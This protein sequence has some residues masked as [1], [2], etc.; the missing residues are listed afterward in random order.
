MCPGAGG[1]F[2]QG[3]CRIEG[4]WWIDGIGGAAVWNLVESGVLSIVRRPRLWDKV[5]TFSS[6]K[7]AI[8]NAP[9]SCNVSGSF[10]G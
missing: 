4:Q 5:T 8:I 2:V 10:R 7:A 6:V 3:Y 1:A 9:R